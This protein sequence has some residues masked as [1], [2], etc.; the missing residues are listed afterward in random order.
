MRKQLLLLALVSLVRITAVD[1]QGFHLGVKAGVNMFKIPDQAFKD[2]FQFGYNLGGFAQIN[3]TKKWG[4]Q[5][6]V[7]WSENT[8]KTATTINAVIPTNYNVKLNYLQIPLLLNYSPAKLLTFQLGPQFGVLIDENV[9][10]VNNGRNAFKNGDFS[11]LGGAQLN[12]GT[13]K[14][15]G[16]YVAGLNELSDITQQSSWRNRGWQLYVGFKFF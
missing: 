7:L 2:G 10:A 11:L 4:L 14:L 12:L 3:F 9:S 6:E 16:R 5:P 1:A 15:G 8:Y 13:L